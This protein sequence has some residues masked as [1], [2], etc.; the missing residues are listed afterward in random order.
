MLYARDIPTG[1]LAFFP[2]GLELYLRTDLPEPAAIWS[3]LE[4][5]WLARWG[6]A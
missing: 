2:G 5:R 4:G 1:W 6:E 3:R